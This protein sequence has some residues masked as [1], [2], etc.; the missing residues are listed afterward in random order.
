MLLYV[1]VTVLSGEGGLCGSDGRNVKMLFQFTKKIYI[2][3]FFLFV[4]A[5]VIYN[6]GWTFLAEPYNFQSKCLHMNLIVY[7][8]FHYFLSFILSCVLQLSPSDLNPFENYVP[9]WLGNLPQ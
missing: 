7:P 1:K 6:F 9:L 8:M 3:D 5:P 2:A 4:S